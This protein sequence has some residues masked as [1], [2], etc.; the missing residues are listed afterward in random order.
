MTED[1]K[2]KSN[3]EIPFEKLLERLEGIVKQLESG[4]LSLEGSLKTYEQ[5]I[6]LVR[7]T[8]T[9]LQNME[10]KIEQLMQDGRKEPLKA[11]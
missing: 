1:Q 6:G 4:E 7:E 9:R 11:E 2:K 5:G 10:G 8:Q 3:D